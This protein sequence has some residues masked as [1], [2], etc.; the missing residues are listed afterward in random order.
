MMRISL[1]AAIVLATSSVLAAPAAVQRLDAGKDGFIDDAYALR[2][3]G[4]AV[5]YITTDGASA[6]TL[7]LAEIGGNNVSVA[8]A[9]T[10]AVAV[11]WLSPARVLVVRGKDGSST[12]QAFTAAGADKGKPIGPFGRFAFTTVDGKRAFVTYTRSEKRTV[13]HAI[14]A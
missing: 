9:P 1:V 13:E 4:K 7:H 8:G 6:A 11:A 2:D 3:D 10:D 12:A 14:A 5:A